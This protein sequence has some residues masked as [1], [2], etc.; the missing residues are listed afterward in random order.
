MAIDSIVPNSDKA[1][2]EN[3]SFDILLL[4]NEVSSYKN[5]VDKNVPKDEIIPKKLFFRPKKT[6]V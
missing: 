4:I 1:M 6:S 5:K 3:N 2:Y